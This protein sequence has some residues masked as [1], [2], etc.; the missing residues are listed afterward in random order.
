MT[1]PASTNISTG[2]GFGIASVTFVTSRDL[3]ADEPGASV[4]T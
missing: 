2:I 4:N 1:E 3:H